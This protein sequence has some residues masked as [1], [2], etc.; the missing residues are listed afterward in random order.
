MCMIKKL[1]SLSQTKLLC[2][3]KILLKCLD[4]LSSHRKFLLY[5]AFHRTQKSAWVFK[6]IEFLLTCVFTQWERFYKNG[7]VAEKCVLFS[8]VHIGYLD[9]LTR[10]CVLFMWYSFK[11][12]TAEKGSF[13]LEEKLKINS[14]KEDG[15][16]MKLRE[17]DT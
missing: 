5:F 17:W 2:S 10:L 13:L 9:H 12:I 1:I 7:N 15:E 4:I 8:L 16:Q 11:L 6:E 3:A 14:G